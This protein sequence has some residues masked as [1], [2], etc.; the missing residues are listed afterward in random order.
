MI[1][2]SFG[3]RTSDGSAD[4][5]TFHPDGEGP[6]P[7]VIF[8]MDGIGIRPDLFSMAGRLASNG[9]YV[10]LPDLYYRAGKQ[11][12]FDP[13]S[14]FNEGS[15]ERE[16]LMK[17]FQSINNTLVMQDT[18]A[19]L[20]FLNRQPAAK[21]DGIGCVGYCM[22]GG[23]ALSAAGTYP[24]RVKAAASFH[25]ASLASDRP[26]SPHRLADRMRAKLFI[27]VAG[28]DPYFPP[29]QGQQLRAA[30]DAAGVPYEYEVFPEVRH[31]FA[32]NGLPVYDREASERHWERLLKLFKGALA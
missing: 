25:G 31:G 28:I 20:D 19:F 30:L 26:D 16:R 11:P 10:L 6:W 12:P 21:T 15:P 9:Y 32:V 24:G 13:A 14:V 27:G 4:A 2:Q 1:E 8:Y 22:G 23:F 18:A 7:A 17:M 5:S 29:E 3:I